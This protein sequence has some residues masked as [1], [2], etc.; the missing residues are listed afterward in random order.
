MTIGS[1]A[2]HVLQ[3]HPI[4]CIT[5]IYT[6]SVVIKKTMRLDVWDGSMS[7]IKPESH[8]PHRLTAD[9]L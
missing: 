4:L 8:V 6:C 3:N 7:I 2:L 5:Y 1:A 9:N